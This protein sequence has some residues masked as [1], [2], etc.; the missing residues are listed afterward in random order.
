MT[1]GQQ[2]QQND[3]KTNLRTTDRFWIIL[4]FTRPNCCALLQYAGNHDRLQLVPT[5][6]EKTRLGLA[7][8]FQHVGTYVRRATKLMKEIA[9]FILVTY[10]GII[11]VKFS[12]EFNEF[13]TCKHKISGESLDWFWHWKIVF[14]T[15]HAIFFFNQLSSFTHQQQFVNKLCYS[16]IFLTKKSQ[17]KDKIWEIYDVKQWFMK[18][19]TNV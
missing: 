16:F 2:Q 18:V 17:I 5:V 9:I 1:T 15:L 7:F 4:C 12:M 10:L 19:C 11:A 6:A 14:C 8:P 13:Q 3:N